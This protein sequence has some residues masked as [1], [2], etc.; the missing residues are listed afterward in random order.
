MLP[1]SGFLC[2]DGDGADDFLTGEV[3]EKTRHGQTVRRHY[4]GF[5]V[6]SVL[7]AVGYVLKSGDRRRSVSSDT[8]TGNRTG[9]AN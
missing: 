5:P 8:L 4:Y 1:C 3:R 6:S 7:S 9:V 2:C